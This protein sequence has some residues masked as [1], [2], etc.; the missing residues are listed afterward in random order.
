M[1][2]SIFLENPPPKN[3]DIQ[4]YPNKDKLETNIS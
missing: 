4:V 2:W 1:N 3:V